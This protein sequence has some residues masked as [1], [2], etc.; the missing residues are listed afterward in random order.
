MASTDARVLIIGDSNMYQ[1]AHIHDPTG[2]GDSCARGSEV[3]ARTQRA[4]EI[5]PQTEAGVYHHR[6]WNKPSRSLTDG[7]RLHRQDHQR[8]PS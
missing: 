2:L 4:Q 6:R 5:R 1:A 3:P 8:A 7:L